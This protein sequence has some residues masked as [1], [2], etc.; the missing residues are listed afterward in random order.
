M[1]EAASKERA[2]RRRSAARSIAAVV[3]AGHGVVHLLGV[4]LQWRLG[5]PGALRYADAYPE[6]G[7]AAGFV[8]GA[9]WLAAGLLF[10]VVAGLVARRDPC[11]RIVAL[12]AVVISVPVLVLNASTAA[13]GLVIDVAVVVALILTGR[14]A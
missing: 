7:T 3:L 9:G 13:A 2:P 10:L 14:R 5:E 4:P 8:A 12:A 6:P 1:T 11:W